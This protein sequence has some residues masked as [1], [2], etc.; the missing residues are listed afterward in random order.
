[1]AKIEIGDLYQVAKQSVDFR[2]FMANIGK[3]LNI[4]TTD[5]RCMN[6]TTDDLCDNNQVNSDNANCDISDD[7]FSDTRAV[8]RLNNFDI[9]FIRN[10]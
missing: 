7:R 2:N 3:I 6:I 9:E 8:F 10:S 4:P 5:S 1:M